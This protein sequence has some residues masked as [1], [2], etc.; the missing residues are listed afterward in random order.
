MENRELEVRGRIPS[1]SREVL[2][3]R[4]IDSLMD[5]E[6]DKY[7]MHGMAQA[8]HTS[9]NS[10]MLE[11]SMWMQMQKMEMRRTLAMF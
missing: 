6:E 2:S 3:Q 7:T 9:I 1:P 11:M 5:L 10:M 8:F 4:I